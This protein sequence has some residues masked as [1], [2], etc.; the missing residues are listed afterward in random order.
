VT[1]LDR[2]FNIIIFAFK[3]GFYP[4]IREVFHPAGKAVLPGNAACLR[5]KKNPL[6]TAR[7]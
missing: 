5:A 2:F 6:Y 1:P 4:S 7:N 3:D